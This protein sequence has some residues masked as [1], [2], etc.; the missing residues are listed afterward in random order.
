MNSGAIFE[1]MC[2]DPEVSKWLER[3]I[4]YDLNIYMVVG[5]YTVLESLIRPHSLQN[6]LQ[7]IEVKLDR[8]TVWGTVSSDELI[9]AVQYRMVQ[10]NSYLQNVENAI[11]EVACNRW[12]AYASRRVGNSG[13][14]EVANIIEATLKPMITKED[15]EWEG[16]IVVADGQVIVL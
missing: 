8:Q 7:Q 6:K 3:A 5:I 10:F 1:T 14:G 9:V 12:E 2:V 15:V 16:E 13:T 4:K 11:L